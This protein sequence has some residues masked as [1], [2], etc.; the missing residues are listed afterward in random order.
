LLKAI[1]R[2]SSLETSPLANGRVSLALQT[3]SRFVPDAR[4]FTPTPASAG[5][6][7][8]VDALRG[9]GRTPAPPRLII[10]RE[11]KS[12]LLLKADEEI[13]VDLAT[14][15]ENAIGAFANHAFSLRIRSRQVR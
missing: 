8:G 2:S 9:T 5:V 1:R 3:S 12:T 7:V 6:A 4:V 11:L 13:V 14:L 10:P 15:R